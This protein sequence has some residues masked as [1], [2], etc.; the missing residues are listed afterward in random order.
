MKAG[1]ET[2][3]LYKAAEKGLEVRLFDDLTYEHARP[4]GAGHQF[5]Y[6]GAAMATLGYAPLY[7]IGRVAINA[8]KPS[9]APGRAANML[10]GYLQAKVGSD[11]P[12]M[13]P[14]E[15]SLRSFVRKRQS[16]RI[17]KVV[18]SALRIRL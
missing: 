5:V 15:P 4:R 2:W 12:F 8:L 6:W 7:A 11:D 18:D 17:V 9:F 3:L 13:R 1:W 16:Q 14:Y 10:R